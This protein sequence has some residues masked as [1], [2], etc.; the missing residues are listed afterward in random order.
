MRKSILR[1]VFCMILLFGIIF[2]YNLDGINAAV[3]EIEVP[4][5]GTAVSGLTTRAGKIW[6]TVKLIIQVTAI[7]IFIFTG[8]KYMY[9]SAD[10]K[11]DL[12]K[13]LVMTFLGVA[14]VFGLTFAVDFVQDIAV[15]LL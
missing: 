1:V 5:G 7:G 11:A 14:L 4:S 10:Q 9:A 3:D 12:K 2:I 13:G 6:N 8:I 15:D